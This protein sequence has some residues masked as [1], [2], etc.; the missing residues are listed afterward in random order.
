MK[1]KL[2]DPIQVGSETIHELE[3]NK[4]KAKH[5]RGMPLQMGMDDMLTLISRCSAQPPS[6][7]D[8]LSFAD[9]TA[10]MEAIGNFLPNGRKTGPMH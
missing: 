7:I 9:M 4:P 2:T 3:L 6:T 1:I 8:E 10:V 5:M